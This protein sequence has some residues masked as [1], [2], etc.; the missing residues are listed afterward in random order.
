[1]ALLA[2][3]TTGTAESPNG[4]EA[5][6]RGDGR[7]GVKLREVG[8][9][10]S[11]IYVSAAP[12]FPD[13]LFVVERDGR[14]VVLK[15]G[16]P[17]GTFLDISD[18]VSTDGERGLLSVAFAPDY[19]DSRRFYVYFTDRNGDIEVDEFRR[20]ADSPIRAEQG[21][22]SQIIS[23]PHPSASNHNGGTLAFGP[24]KKLYLATGDG[25]ASS[26]TAQDRNNLLGKLLRI[27]PQTSIRRGYRIPNGNPFRGGGGA[28]EI[29][30]VGLRNPF[31]FSFDSRKP[32]IAIADVGESAFEEVNYLKLSEARNANFGWNAFEGRSRHDSSTNLSEK[33]HDAPMLDYPNGPGGTCAVTGGITVHDD[34]LTSLR[35][36][37]VYADL[38]AGE[39]RSF[40]PKLRGNKAR[41]DRAL[42]VDL[43][44]PVAF[45]EDSKGHAYVVSLSAGVFRL[46]PKK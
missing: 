21:S 41:A 42:G 34:G 25:G 9:F 32:L 28:P 2:V 29:F 14:I 43:E 27:D 45:G 4:G 5:A 17:A 20:S 18:I 23:I 15:N 30:A 7:G 46:A 24:D 6:K 44:Q 33:K 10:D 35:G 40:K 13:L 16:K 12:G 39:L 38:C 1:M 11:P 3:A 22:R 8:N 19:Q 37:Y 36:R 26:E 31:R